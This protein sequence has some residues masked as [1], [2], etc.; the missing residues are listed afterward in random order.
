[1]PPLAE[2]A[3]KS[4]AN[5][6]PLRPIPDPLEGAP[7]SVDAASFK[8]IVP[9]LSTDADVEKAWGKPKRTAE[10]DGAAVHLY[11]VE[12]FK[13]VEV[14]YADGKV[15]S[16]VIRF[17]HPYP[18]DA[19]A[20]ILELAAIRPVAVS[21]E[22]GEVLGLSYPER[23]VLFSLETGTESGK[24]SMKVAQIILEP[25]SAEPFVLRAE[26]TMGSRYDLSRRD[27]EQAIKLE[28]ANARAHWLLSRVL[29]AGGQHQK[30]IAAAAEAVRLD[31]GDAQF[32]VTH[33]QTLAETGQFSEALDEAQ[34][35][36]QT[37]QHRPHV[38][39]QATSL[40][41][42]LLASGPNPDF[43]RALGL[44]TQAI[45]L[46]DPLLSETHPAIRIA[47]KEVLVDAH[48]GAAH[49]IAWGEWKNKP[50]AVSKWLERAVAVADDLVNNEGGSQEQ[51]FRVYTRA[52]GAYVG[53]RGEID[54]EP[55]IAAAVDSGDKLIA[56]ARD[57]GRKTQLQ[58][59]TGHGPLRR[60][61]DLPDA[62][63][64]RRRVETRPI[65]RRT[66]WP[67]PT[68]QN[69]RPRWVSYWAAS[70]SGWAPSMRCATTTTRRRSSGSTRRRR[71]WSMRHPR[72]SLPTW[73][74]TASRW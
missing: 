63:G 69:L 40:M 50:K 27:L 58:W 1:M 22:M 16:V 45:Q 57:P 47:A 46:A 18:A 66:I 23:G 42:D 25:I 74:A 30:A 35:A 43:R 56:A 26:T 14:Q 62:P 24:A 68:T 71:L 36:V 20:K 6:E 28:P 11:S 73:A 41:G 67:K 10:V 9:G 44:H 32:R 3:P 48:L 39:A 38:K 70:I 5:D 29:A 54:P 34:K 60:R 12:P 13:R 55:T 4:N 33:A 37:S 53:V 49:D 7:V 31:P 59:R 17:D 72:T 2:A 8:G 61:P 21:N 64:P 52:L 15:S 65:G 51:L 19:V